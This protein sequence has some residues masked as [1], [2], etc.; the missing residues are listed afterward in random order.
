MSKGKS[1]FFGSTNSSNFMQ[2]SSFNHKKLQLL[3]PVEDAA[4]TQ[5]SRLELQKVRLCLLHMTRLPR[6]F[7]CRQ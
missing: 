6:S 5:Y 1:N 2:R 4:A 3:F 7:T